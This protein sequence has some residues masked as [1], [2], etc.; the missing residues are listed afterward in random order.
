MGYFYRTIIKPILF[1][2]SA[3]SVHEFFLHTGHF[4]GNIPAL[5]WAIRKTFRY[6][7]TILNQ[8]IAGIDFKN[9]IGLAAGFDYDADLIQ[10]APSV[11]FGFSTIG[12]VTNGAYS[13]NPRPMLGRLPK[14]RSLLVN[15][16]FKS[17]GIISVVAKAEQQTKGAPLGISIGSTNKPYDT[18]EDLIEDIMKSFLYTADKPFF[19]FIELNISCPNLINIEHLPEKT[20]SPH[21]LEMLLNRLE[22]AHIHRPLFIKM[23]VEKSVEDTLALAEVASHHAFVTGLIFANLVKDR[24][25]PAL[26]H[27][28]VVSAGKGNFSGKPTEALS[29]ALISAV[30]KQ[31]HDRFVIVGCGG[32]FTGKDAY[33]KI[34]LGASLVQMITGMIYQG[35]QQIGVIN[36]ELAKLLQDDGYQTISEAIGTHTNSL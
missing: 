33:E 8:S 34:R 31:Y 12:T 20:D 9:P 25:N 22:D 35:P 15:K 2:F 7:N 21:G 24:S 6:D 1:R 5:S 16:G 26:D 13:G 18:L 23:H 11:G 36:K 14:S 30:Y 28:E 10:I 32:V 27:G 3:D 17:K 4:L 19:D 29:N